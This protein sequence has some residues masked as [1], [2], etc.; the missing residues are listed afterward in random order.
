MSPEYE[1]VVHVI[2]I[3]NLI[4]IVIRQLDLHESISYIRT[5]MWIQ[6]AVNNLFVFE[7][8]ANY[9]VHGLIKAYSYFKNWPETICQ[10]LNI[11]AM[12]LFFGNY[13]DVNIYSMAAKVL[14]LTI[15]IRASKMLTL[16]YEVKDFRI[17]IETMRNLLAPLLNLLGILM[18]IYYLFALV[19]MLL[20]GGK[21]R[22]GIPEI[23]SDASI[24]TTYYLDNFNDLFSS[25]VTLFSLMVVNNWMI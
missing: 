10:G 15:F 6:I 13:P 8:L 22:K 14:E 7:L 19:G 21:I 9:Y 11:Y 4:S 12:I 25:F 18:I 1:L 5:W 3:C 23:E 17:I 24:P 20:F 2:G 16:L